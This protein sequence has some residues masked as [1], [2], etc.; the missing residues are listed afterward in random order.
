MANYILNKRK[1][2]DEDPKFDDKILKIYRAFNIMEKQKIDDPRY[3]ETLNEMV[4]Y[5]AQQ[6]NTDIKSGKDFMEKSS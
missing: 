3:S 2:N 4:L 5:I 1:G 6:K